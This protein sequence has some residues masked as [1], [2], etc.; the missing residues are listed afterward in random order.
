MNADPILARLFTETAAVHRPTMA[1]NG[2]GGWTP[3]IPD[4]P[5]HTVRGR[6]RSWTTEEELHARQGGVRI[7]HVFYAEPGADLARD[8]VLKVR[9]LDAVVRSV[10]HPSIGDHHTIV[11]LEERQT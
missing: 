8:D 1:S 9:G 4:E 11:D 7:S 10:R 3:T 2:S 5:T 6:L